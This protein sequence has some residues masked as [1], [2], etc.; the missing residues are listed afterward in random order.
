MKALKSCLLRWE[1][2]EGAGSRRGGLIYFDHETAA[3]DD[4]AIAACGAGV[5][6]VYRAQIGLCKH[7]QSAHFALK[8]LC[9]LVS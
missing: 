3:A 1:R 8:Y 6:G 4:D 9:V 5:S 7:T 2:G